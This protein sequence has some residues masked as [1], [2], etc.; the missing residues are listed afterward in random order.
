MGYYSSLVKKELQ[1]WLQNSQT[2]CF[3]CLFVFLL[4]MLSW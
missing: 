1:V 4:L 2:S 3:S